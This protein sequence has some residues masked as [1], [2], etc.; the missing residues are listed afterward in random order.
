[1]CV[2]AISLG[3][4]VSREVFERMWRSNDDGFGLIYRARGGAGILKG[5]MDE[6]EAWEV[7]S[8]LP[9]G[10]PHVLHFRLATHGGVR[11]ELT[12]P[13]VVSE[14][15]PILEAGVVKEPALA[16]N[17]IWGLYAA[18]QKEVGLRL[19]GPVSDSRVLAAWLGR[20]VRERPLREVL[21]AHYAE[22][23]SAGRVVVVDPTTWRIHVV[24][25]WIRE[26][27][28]LFSNG[29]YRED[30]PL[31]PKGVCDWKDLDVDLGVRL[32]ARVQV[33][34]KGFAGAKVLAEIA[35]PEPGPAWLDEIDP[36]AYEIDPPASYWGADPYLGWAPRR[37]K[38]SGGVLRQALLKA[39][40]EEGIPELVEYLELG[41]YDGTLSAQGLVGFLEAVPPKGNGLW[42][43]VLWDG[44]RTKEAR[45]G[46]LATNPLLREFV[47]R[48]GAVLRFLEAAG[49]SPEYANSF[50]SYRDVFGWEVNED[51]MFVSRKGAVTPEEAASLL[52][53]YG[54]PGDPFS[55]DEEGAET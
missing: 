17:G 37:R 29:S 52:W 24:G 20:L 55:L 38:R 41:V 30:R 36:P 16:H 34:P 18:K 42:A 43:V 10:V 26:G 46:F 2:I 8:Q 54:S 11:P 15:S 3:E 4:K 39:A 32:G 47:R 1:M 14:G 45:S 22:V 40:E 23:V 33:G 25:D 28:F 12:H 19:D 21:E 50:T 35:P 6:E 31:L 53:E 49:V 13:F 27:P 5:I 48:E 7:Y 44:T 51:G 9:E